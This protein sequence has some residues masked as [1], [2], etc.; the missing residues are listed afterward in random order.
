MNNGARTTSAIT[1]RCDKL[2]QVDSC[3]ASLYARAVDTEHALPAVKTVLLNL[4]VYAPDPR[5]ADMA[6]GHASQ[7]LPARP[8]RAIIV[9]SGS[10]ASS[11]GA[12]VSVLCGI[13]ERG[14]R[15]LCGEV[16]HVHAARGGATGA[17]MPLLLADVPVYL[18]VL[19]DVPPQQEDFGDLLRVS[20]HLIVDSRRFSSLSAGMR[21]VDALRRADSGSRI[22]QDL[23]WVSL[24]DWRE[25]TAQHF[26]APAVRRHL[27]EVT[28]LEITCTC[29]PRAPLPD[30]P[31]LLFA[32]WLLER[33]QL[34]IRSV[35]HSKDEGYRIDAASD[36]RSAIIRMLPRESD[37][38]AGELTSVVVRC[39]RGG[40]AACF[41]TQRS[42]ETELLLTEDCREVCLPPERVEI[43]DQDD[44]A[45]AVQALGQYRRDEAYEHA[46]PVALDI[47]GRIELGD[48]SGLRL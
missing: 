17:V 11:P 3:L 37:G 43:A 14:D 27:A 28:E 40:D 2:S 4:V 29:G 20:S 13:S 42:S 39:G 8:C 7:V 31:P 48:E 33:L 35:F 46:L 47:I 5:T 9:E 16:I 30:S 6:T 25:A 34:N 24:R 22:V 26:D 19:G 41:R 32:S 18:W 21:A 44:V 38:Q 15:R 12:A 23:A 10:D 36:D 45:L 1:E